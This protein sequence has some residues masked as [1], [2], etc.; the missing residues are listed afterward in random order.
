M[1]LV[2]K[3]FLSQVVLLWIWGQTYSNLIKWVVKMRVYFSYVCKHMC[4]WAE[5]SIRHFSLLLRHFPRLL[6]NL[7]FK[8]RMLPDFELINSSGLAGWQDPRIFLSQLLYCWDGRHSRLHWAFYVGTGWGFSSNPY[9]YMTTSYLPSLQENLFRFIFIS[10]CFIFLDCFSIL[11]NLWHLFHYLIISA[12]FLSYF[13]VYSGFVYSPPCPTLLGSIPFPSPMTLCTNFLFK[14]IK[15][16]LTVWIFSD[17]LSATRGWPT[18]LDYILWETCLSHSQ[19]LTS[20]RGSMARGEISY[21]TPI[22]TV[23]IALAWAYT[24]LTQSVPTAVI[25]YMQLPRC[26]FCDVIYCLCS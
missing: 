2:K 14:L 20:S 21:L 22:P 25:S 6:S 11:F 23:G 18:Y 19:W 3:D 24:G 26:I 4:M 10:F 8:R 13:R 16:N 12:Q 7:F 15:T 9:N 17:M 1:I 5:G